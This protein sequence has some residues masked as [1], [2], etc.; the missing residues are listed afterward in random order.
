MKNLKE[1]VMAEFN[2]YQDL[3]HSDTEFLEADEVM[4][5]GEFAT[6]ESAV[7]LSTDDDGMPYY[8][9]VSV[10]QPW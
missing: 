6:H 5:M 9:A 7:L 2:H 4:S 1:D 10:L 8:E 3:M